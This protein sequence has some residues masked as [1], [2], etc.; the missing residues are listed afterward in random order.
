MRRLLAISGEF[1]TRILEGHM[2][3]KIKVYSICVNSGLIAGEDGNI[4]QFSKAEWKAKEF[5]KTEE[6]VDFTGS[7]KQARHVFKTGQ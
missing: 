6:K 7:N 5:P 3:G 1:V 4:Y 2:K